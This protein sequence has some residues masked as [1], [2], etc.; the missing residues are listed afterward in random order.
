MVGLLCDV[1]QAFKHENHIYVLVFIPKLLSAGQTTLHL[2]HVTFYLSLYSPSAFLMA[3]I[4]PSHILY[5]SFV[6]CVC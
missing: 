3:T 2:A 6:E 5:Q 1:V 4:K